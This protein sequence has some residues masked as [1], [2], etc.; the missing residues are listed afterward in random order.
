[1]T[2]QASVELEQAK[3]F[4]DPLHQECFELQKL[5]SLTEVQFGREFC[6]QTARRQRNKN[7]AERKGF[8]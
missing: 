7:I 3:K 1:M 8:E 5:P 6:A 2:D 4:L